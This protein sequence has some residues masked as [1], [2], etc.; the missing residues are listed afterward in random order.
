MWNLRYEELKSIKSQPW[1]VINLN[2]AIKGLK[3]NQSGDPSGIISELFKPGVLGQDLQEGLLMLCNNMKSELYIPALVQLANITTIFKNKGSRLDMANDRGIF[4]LSIFRKIVDKLIY[5]DKYEKIDSYMSDSNIGARRMKNIRN[6]LFVIHAIINSVV[7]GNSECIDIQIY[8]LVQAFDSLWVEDCL[9]D[10]YDALDE[11][12]KDDKVALLYD[13]NKENKVAVNTAM[14]QTDRIEIERI[15][16]QGGTWGSLLCSNHIDTLGRSCR[17]TGQ[18]M[19]TYKNKV[20]VLPL[21]MVDDLLGVARCGHDSLALNIF[22]NTQIELK[23]LKF[24]T[25]DEKGKS[26][27]HV[28]HVGKDSA[29]CPKLEVHGT[30]M[31]TIKF[32]TLFRYRVKMANYGKNFRG[33]INV[34]LCPLYNTLLDNQKMCF[35]NCPVLKKHILITGSYEQI[36]DTFVSRETVQ[37]LMKI[38]KFREENILSRNEANSTRKHIGLM[39]ASDNVNYQNC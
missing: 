38:D 22:I 19:Y 37:I 29:I 26:K 2:K 3:I 30:R 34:V 32:P 13:I 33:K 18:H 12:T 25:A 6:H 5:H 27:C 1:Q 36:F 16:T 11:D 8:D 15:V 21:S 39:G 20:K 28:M 31:H 24:H 9:N 35:E 23:K 14:G 10:V 4:I 17:S 7:Q